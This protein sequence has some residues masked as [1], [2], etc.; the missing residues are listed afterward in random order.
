[1]CNDKPRSV[2]GFRCSKCHS[3]DVLAFQDTDSYVL[4]C[5]CG[6]VEVCDLGEVKF[7]YDFSAHK[8]P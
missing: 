2:Q 7:V 1:M 8:V 5:E 3:R 4:W 6:N